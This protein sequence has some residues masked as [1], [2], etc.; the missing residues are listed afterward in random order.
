MVPSARSRTCFGCGFF[1]CVFE[2]LLPLELRHIAA[3]AR[4]HCAH[5]RVVYLKYSLLEHVSSL[6]FL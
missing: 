5:L 3:Q 6:Q 4:H 1:T 2:N